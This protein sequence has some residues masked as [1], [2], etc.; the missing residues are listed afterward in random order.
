M[1]LIRKTIKAKKQSVV[2]IL[3]EE[4]KDTFCKMISSGGLNTKNYYTCKTSDDTPICRLCLK[5]AL[6]QR[7][8]IEIKGESFVVQLQQE[9]RK[10]IEQFHPIQVYVLKLIENKYYIGQSANLKARLAQHHEGKG[11]E[12][13]KQYYPIELFKTIETGMTEWRITEAIENRVTLKMMTE[14]GYKNVRGGFWSQPDENTIY[15]TLLKHEKYIA[16]L[17]YDL[18]NILAFTSK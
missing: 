2:H 15:K 14:H 18:S 4:C 17:G 8:L 13:T 7:N 12:W 6:N 11:S 1:F 16:G 10:N 9:L 5:I 3:N